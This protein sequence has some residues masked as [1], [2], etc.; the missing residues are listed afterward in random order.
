MGS[1]GGCG[2]HQMPG[3]RQE[4][5]DLFLSPGDLCCPRQPKQRLG[6]QDAPAARAPP[7]RRARGRV[8]AARG[9]SRRWDG[10][11]AAPRTGLAKGEGL[12]GIKIK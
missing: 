12:H 1:A 6:F 7:A 9:G 2:H 11:I 4:G 3:A 5:S 10:G 8:P